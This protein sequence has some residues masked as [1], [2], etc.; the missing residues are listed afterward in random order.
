MLVQFLMQS[1]TTITVQKGNGLIL[2][3]CINV[4]RKTFILPIG[5]ARKWIIYNLFLV[6]K[7][8]KIVNDCQNSLSLYIHVQLAL[9]TDLSIVEAQPWCSTK[10]QKKL[11][12][13]LLSEQS[14]SE[15]ATYCMIPT[16]WHSGKDETGDSQKISG[17]QRLEGREES[18]EHGI[19]ME[20]KLY[21]TI[22]VDTCPYVCQNS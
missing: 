21:D 18:V 22:M 6:L 13:T 7:F 11:K 5:L 1:K 3:K 20:V 9:Q 19:F 8:C 15:K 2:F 14:Q 16:V 17:C 10:R 12:R 4:L